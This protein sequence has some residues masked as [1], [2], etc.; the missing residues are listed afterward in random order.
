MP[1]V[2]IANRTLIL[3]D[4]CIRDDQGSKYRGF[5]QQVLPHIGDAYRQ[6]EDGFRS[7]LG[8][9]VIGGE[10]ARSI[11]YS[12]RWA[13]RPNFSGQM[14]RLFNRGHLEEGRF[15]ALILAAGLTAYQQDANGNQFRITHAEGHFGGSSDGVLVGIPDLVAGTPVLAEFKT[16]NKKWFEDLA[17]ESWRKY[18]DALIN[19]KAKPVAFDGKGVRDAKFEHYVQMQIY[20]RKMGLAVALYVAVCKDTDEIYCELVPL[21]TAIADQ[22]LDR[23]QQI[24]YLDQ[25]PKKINESSG[26]WKC[27]FCD[28]HTVCH[29]GGAPARNCRTCSFSIPVAEQNGKWMCRLREREID[30]A[31]QLIGCEEYVVKKGF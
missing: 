26:Y 5:L 4:K 15:I 28:H 29:M 25:P 1:N 8:A 3:F 13:A 14:L 22:F 20:M 16:H 11:W 21:D 7:H 27:K 12:F 24:V 10:C 9:S 30:K 23:G 31:T 18:C 2:T 17:G 6:N 19:P